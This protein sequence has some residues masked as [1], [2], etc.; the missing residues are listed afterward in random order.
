MVVMLVPVQYLEVSQNADNSDEE[1]VKYPHARRIH[2]MPAHP[3][4]EEMN[5]N[6]GDRSYCFTI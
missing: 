4:F 6:P 2:D 5:S 1:D 3:S